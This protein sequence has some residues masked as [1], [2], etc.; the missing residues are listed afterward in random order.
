MIYHYPSLSNYDL[1]LFRLHGAGLANHLF[2][3]YRAFQKS[4]QTNGTFLF[5]PMVQ[6][7]I[8]P[9]IRREHDKR[10]YC[11]LFQRRSI[12]ELI[13]LKVLVSSNKFDESNYDL[14]DM[15]K[16]G[17]IT[18]KGIEG[19]HSSIEKYYFFKFFNNEFRE[20]FVNMLMERTKNKARL[21]SELNNIRKDDICV[22]IRR[23][24]FPDKL[25][26]E[27]YIKSI[28]YVNQEF[29]GSKIRIFTDDKSSLG[30]NVLSIKNISVDSSFN[31]WHALIKMSAHGTI[32]ASKSTFAMWS[33]FIGNQKV[34][35]NSESDL[36]KFIN[37]KI[38]II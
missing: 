9:I 24:D 14:L 5:P 21:S 6:V 36:S 26:D 12:N 11:N 15:G 2:P 22:H 3:M 13:K 38:Q 30:D 4:R 10:I 7:K 34:I 33:A 28:N 1:L 16:D 27:W 29:P 8:G 37:N 35:T 31:A 17:V 18:Y 19:N 25:S 32:L 23:G 20:D